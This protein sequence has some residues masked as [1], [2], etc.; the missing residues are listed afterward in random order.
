MRKL[1]GVIIFI[2]VIVCDSLVVAASGME[3]DKAMLDLKWTEGETTTQSIL[4]LET[5][6]DWDWLSLGILGKFYVVPI[7]NCYSSL[8]SKLVFPKL[9]EDLIFRVGYDWDDKYQIY[10]AGVNYSCQPLQQTA[11]EIGYKA[12][13]RHPELDTG[14]PYSLNDEMVRF[15][16]KDKPWQYSFKLTRNDKEYYQNY[17]QWTSLKFQL[18]Q[19]IAW[20]PQPN[21]QLQ[22]EYQEDT[23]DYPAACDKDFWKE[24][25]GLKGE[26]AN[27][28]E[29]H[30]SWEYSKL[31]WER[32]FEPYR[33]DQ[34]IKLKLQSKL[35]P[36]TKVIIGAVCAD[37]NYD[38][39]E[40]DYDEP[41]T[42]YL[43]ETDLKS[44]VVSK[45]GVEVQ[46]NWAP[47]TLEIGS[48]LGKVDY[49]SKLV[50]DT[51][52]FGIYGSLDWKL[53]QMELS[54]KFAPAGDLSQTDAYY[55][56][57]VIYKPG[58]QVD[59]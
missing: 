54:L 1:F 52:R 29:V 27:R 9:N 6:G 45:I 26:Y 34:Q 42:Y 57:A 39:Q 21:I 30:Y 31:D 19:S 58:K 3:L 18:G 15:T 32:G 53:H 59:N 2:G 13:E 12:E 56:L 28:S 5:S 25:W 33:N 24:A 48:F 16:W 20:H 23:G 38:S 14:C 4:H 17:P 47:Y 22:L 41:G 50:T 35:N 55:Q 37:L 11:L 46:F 10:N 49:D 40:Q 8:N 51:I 36:T 43:P 7:E 44:R